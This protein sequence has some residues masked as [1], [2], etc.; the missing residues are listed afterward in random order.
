MKMSDSHL[1]CFTFILVFSLLHFSRGHSWLACTDYTEKNGAIWYGDKCRGFPRGA[2]RKAPKTGVFGGDSGIN[3]TLFFLRGFC[4]VAVILYLQ[5][6]IILPM[7]K[8]LARSHEMTIANTIEITQW[9]F[10]TLVSKSY[11][12]IP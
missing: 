10:T 7:K 8:I 2:H 1:A 12:C 6:T 3:I 11:L 9:L 5:A 4:D